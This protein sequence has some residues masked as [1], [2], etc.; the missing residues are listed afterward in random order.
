VTQRAVIKRRL[1]RRRYVPDERGRLGRAV[2]L[3]VLMLLA[4]VLFFAV[5]T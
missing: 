2:L 1:P 4:L 5:A 3:C